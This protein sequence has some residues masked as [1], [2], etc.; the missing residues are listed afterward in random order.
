VKCPVIEIIQPIG[1]KMEEEVV[2]LKMEKA[3]VECPV[4]EIRQAIS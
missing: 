1:E 3:Q 2:D 4:I